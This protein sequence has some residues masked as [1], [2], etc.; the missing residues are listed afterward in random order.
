MTSYLLISHE[1]LAQINCLTV[2][3]ALPMPATAKGFISTLS[4]K[5]RPFYISS[6]Y[7]LF[8]MMTGV[9]SGSSAAVGIGGVRPPV[10][11][12]PEIIIEGNTNRLR[13]I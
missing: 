11:A 8:R 5:T 6:G 1:P 12:R 2:A 9:G 13:S 10:V 4:S 3:N 7:G